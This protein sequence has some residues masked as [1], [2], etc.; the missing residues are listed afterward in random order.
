METQAS[1]DERSS[2]QAKP[3]SLC[4]LQAFKPIADCRLRLED[5]GP[6]RVGSWALTFALRLGCDEERR[7][8]RLTGN[9]GAASSYGMDGRY[10]LY[11][12]A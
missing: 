12:M 8:W 1:L 9:R 11:R 2:V 6:G 3:V 7:D 10:L 5:G 4:A